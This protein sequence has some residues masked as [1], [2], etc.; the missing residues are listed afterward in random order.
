MCT[1]S[2]NRAQD[3]DPYTDASNDL[4]LQ[5][6]M[7]ELVCYIWD[8]YLQLYDSAPEIFLMGVGNAYLGVKML[9]ISRGKSPKPLSFHTDPPRPFAFLEL[10]LLP[11][12]NKQTSNFGCR[13][14]STS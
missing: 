1:P 3:V 7:R 11:P 5:S 4:E 9:L 10:T 8:N 13:A 2:A 6:Q 12:S 14:W